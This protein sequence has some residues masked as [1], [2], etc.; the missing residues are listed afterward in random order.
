MQPLKP[1]VLIVDDDEADQ[2]FIGKTL[3][4][5]DIDV[6][7]ASSGEEVV[8]V[9]ENILPDLII[10]D[11]MMPG[12]NGFEIC[13]RLSKNQRTNEI[14]I[15]F[16]SAR[17]D[18]E[19]IT[20]CFSMGA[21]DYIT[22][23]FV[24]EELIARVKTQLDLKKKNVRLNELNK[25]LEKIVSERT[26]ELKAANKKLK[27]YN[28]A[29]QV[30]LEKREKDKSDLEK[31]L[32]LN[33]REVILPFLTALKKKDTTQKKRLELIRICE[34]NIEKIISPFV[35]NL[36]SRTSELGFTHKE[37][38]IANLIIQGKSSQEISTLLNS[39]DSTIN[40]HRNN[41]RKKLGI[42]N[43]KE[44]LQTYLKRLGK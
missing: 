19:A 30:L 28:T 36:K 6:A 14:P 8:E 11:I 10:L 5:A 31:R 38:T 16:L 2:K 1:F 9:L 44:N 15:I 13:R 39:S 33:A 35:S 42:K 26:T 40:F 12:M 25:N 34:N 24:I 32:V 22:K 7:L 29:L 17:N 27:D 18:T 4:N 37:L 41:I 23:P 20:K 21:H 3:S 43:K